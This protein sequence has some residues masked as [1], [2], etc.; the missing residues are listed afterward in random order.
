MKMLLLVLCA[1]FT[2][3]SGDDSDGGANENTDADSNAHPGSC[4]FDYAPAQIEFSYWENDA[5]VLNRRES[6]T[7]NDAGYPTSWQFHDAPV[8]PST[9][10][11]LEATVWYTYDNAH[12]L[13]NIQI[14][15]DDVTPE[16]DTDGSCTIASYV[17][18]DDDSYPDQLIPPWRPDTPS[19]ITYE[20]GRMV[21][22]SDDP[23][24]AAKNTTF[25]YDEN[26]RLVR[27]DYDQSERAQREHRYL[28][29]FSSIQGTS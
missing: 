12:R 5:W 1:L 10:W 14:C 27:E 24:S 16:T 7:Y 15:Y 18:L 4:Q 13:T 23:M 28:H 19:E 17:Y 26:G 29:F 9:E 20:D 21:Q 11:I 3:C 8:A 6:I 25:I 22:I 2:A